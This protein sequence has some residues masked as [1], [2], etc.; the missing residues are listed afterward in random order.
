MSALDTIRPLSGHIGN[1]FNTGAPFA[2]NFL[3]TIDAYF[4]QE[5]GWTTI[6]GNT[7][8]WYTG[9]LAV[10]TTVIQSELPFEEFGEY[11]RTDIVLAEGMSILNSDCFELLN[12]LNAHAAGWVVWADPDDGK[13][14]VSIRTALAAT[15][16]WW[17][18]IFLGCLPLALTVA[19]ANAE[20]F[21][22][23][24]SGTVALRN[25]PHRG[26]RDNLDSWI[27]GVRLGPR[28]PSA[29]LDLMFT[30]KDFSE[31]RAALEE[32][33]PINTVVI[34]WPLHISTQDQNGC[35]FSQVRN[36][37][38]SDLGRGWQFSSIES[39]YSDRLLPD[40]PVSAENLER[41]ATRNLDLMTSEAWKTIMGGWVAISE[42]GF[43]RQMFIPAQIM[44]TI[45]RDGAQTFGAIAAFMQAMFETLYTREEIVIEIG[46]RSPTS[47]NSE[48][49]SAVQN[50]C[51]ANGP[52]AWSYFLTPSDQPSFGTW[53][54]DDEQL[55][56]Q[57][58]WLSPRHILVCSF[59][60]FNP[61]GPSVSS[62]ELGLDGMQWNLFH[63]LRHPFGS[64][65]EFLDSCPLAD[66]SDALPFKII[67]ALEIHEVLG[68]GPDWM[69]ICAP[70]FEDAIYE[71]LRLFA[72]KYDATELTQRIRKML[73]SQ[74]D[75]W[76]R[77]SLGNEGLDSVEIESTIDTWVNLVTDP[78]IISG[79][80]LYI[81]SA[82]E[83]AK[84][85]SLGKTQE[86]EDTA[87]AIRR[88]VY[89]RL[90][91][92]FTFRNED[93]LVIQHPLGSALSG[94]DV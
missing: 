93:G 18:T 73:V 38:Q 42:F 62:L 75:P 58:E 15:H 47:H 27:T 41:V 52:F 33:F 65:V 9:R 3:K 50:I 1:T 30:A 80:Q 40:G 31:M 85:F 66:A 8:T 21:A 67:E 2:H 43:V 11:A 37:W 90:L 14:K 34:N 26:A 81:R 87:A 55:G 46:D 68:S 36:H 88:T 79:H 78:T 16:W 51:M 64:T 4:D 5:D 71:G 7:W 6:E 48:F 45:M 91:D 92:D 63:V 59:G 74:G 76:Q 22:E 86:A 82:W 94:I 23:L 19:D 53:N 69:E 17:Q 57:L 70:A 12:N 10:T 24:T 13:I 54:R 29:S 44:E 89:E 72:E 77:L 25:H 35:T 61:A 60:V 83:G 49:D 28:E 20:T 39:T 84:I 32:L 56:D